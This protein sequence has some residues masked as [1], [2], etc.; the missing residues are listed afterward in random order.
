MRK[1]VGRLIE[2]F[3]APLAAEREAEK[4]AAYEER[5]AW[6]IAN[7]PAPVRPQEG[8]SPS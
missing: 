5:K 7:P 2:W 1:Q 6:R 4:W 8:Q 3:L